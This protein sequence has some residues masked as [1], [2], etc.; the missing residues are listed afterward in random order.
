VNAIR[1]P[2]SIVTASSCLAAIGPAG[3][4]LPWVRSSDEQRTADIEALGLTATQLESVATWIG[5]QHGLGTWGWPHVLRSLATARAF[6]RKFGPDASDLQVLLPALPDA[7]V[8]AYLADHP[9]SSNPRFATNGV[10]EAIRRR[11]RPAPG[12]TRLGYELLGDEDDGDFHSW[13]CND[14]E[15]LVHQQLGISVNQFG[16]IDDLDAAVGAAE[17][18]MQ[19]DVGA[20]PVWWRPWLLI[21]YPTRR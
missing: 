6:V 10:E 17:L 4:A 18:L 20:E 1:L 7:M 12:G 13:Y 19:D 21:A 14:L 16:L 15:P 11:E 5:E 2:A 8:D 9:V 3:S